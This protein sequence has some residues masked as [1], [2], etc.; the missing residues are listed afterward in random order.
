[1]YSIRF[2]DEA[3]RDLKRLDRS[4]ILSISRKL[5]WLSKNVESL[6]PQWLHENLAGLA[7]L[8]EGDYRIIYQPI[9]SEGVIVIH[10]IGHRSEVYKRR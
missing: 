3:V 7:K 8:R 10:F 5:E 1:M 2:L 9:E 4:V 6:E